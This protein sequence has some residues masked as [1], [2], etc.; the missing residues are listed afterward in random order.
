MNMYIDNNTCTLTEL[1]THTYI[2]IIIYIHLDVF[3]M[4][5][6]VNKASVKIG[7]R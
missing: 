2:I 3:L 7:N 4:F 6:L 5:N 1:D